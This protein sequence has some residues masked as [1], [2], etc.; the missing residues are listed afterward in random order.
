MRV[1]YLFIYLLIIYISV[2]LLVVSIIVR[3]PVILVQQIPKPVPLTQLSSKHVPVVLRKPPIY[4]QARSEHPVLILF[5][6]VILYVT[7]PFCAVINVKKNAIWETV[8]L[9]RLS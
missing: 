8:H 9:A 5:L 7:R 4:C 3:N 2:Y 1:F 6:H